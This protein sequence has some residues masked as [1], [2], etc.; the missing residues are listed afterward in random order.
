MPIY[1]CLWFLPEAS[2]RMGGGISR[3]MSECRLR[4]TSISCVSLEI[5]GVSCCK[6]SL[7]LH[8][9][10]VSNVGQFGLPT[11]AFWQLEQ[12]RPLEGSDIRGMRRQISHGATWCSCRISGRSARHHRPGYWS[13][14][15][16]WWRIPPLHP[17]L[18]ILLA[19]RAFPGNIF[20]GRF[21]GIIELPS[22]PLSD[23]AA[24]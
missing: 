23:I 13:C 1:I 3:G 19:R 8:G 16:A 24:W 2:V 6:L 20:P 5:R 11:C 7:L 4:V 18:V 9:P 10:L 17:R 14:G 22:L 15:G 21:S 12:R